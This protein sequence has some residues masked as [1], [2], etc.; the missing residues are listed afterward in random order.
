MNEEFPQTPVETIHHFSDP[1]VA[2][3]FMVQ[4]RWALIGT[5]SYESLVSNEWTLEKLRQD[6][7]TFTGSVPST[8]P[9]SQCFHF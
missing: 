5:L 9:G 3:D 1:Q 6:S 7:S 2:F 8:I 4:L